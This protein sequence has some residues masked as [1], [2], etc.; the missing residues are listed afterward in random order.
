MAEANGS[1]I[2]ALRV[3]TENLEELTSSMTSHESTLKERE[4]VH[5]AELSLLSEK[6]EKFRPNELSVMRMN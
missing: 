3:I 6:V 1:K 4:Q 2:D 5:V